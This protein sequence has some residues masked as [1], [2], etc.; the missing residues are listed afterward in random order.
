MQVLDV[1]QAG[2]WQMHVFEDEQVVVDG[3]GL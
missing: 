2:A 1:E 3:P